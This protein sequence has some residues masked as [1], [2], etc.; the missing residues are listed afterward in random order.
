[1]PIDLVGDWREELLV[2]TPD[3]LRLYLS[4]VPAGD[5]RVCLMQDRIY[6]ADIAMCAMAYHRP[7]MLSCCPAAAASPPR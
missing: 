2:F 3:E 6:R 5:R 4:T 7:A 1:M